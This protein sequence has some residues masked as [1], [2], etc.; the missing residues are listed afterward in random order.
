LNILLSC[1]SNK[2]LVLEWI[3]ITIKNLNIKSKVFAG[4][5]D[6]NVVSKYFCD[7]FWHMPILKEKNFQKIFRFLKKKRIRFI[8]PSS[9]KELHFWAKYKYF[10]KKNKIFV[11]VSELKTINLCIDKLKFYNFLKDNKN[12][13]FTSN[14][15]ENFK[16]KTRLVAKNRYGYGSKNIFLNLSKKEIDLIKEKKDFVY[17]EFIKGKEFS[18]DCF[19]DNNYNLI[20]CSSRYRNKINNGESEITT[21]FRSSKIKKVI[22]NISKKFKFQGH[23]MFQGILSKKY[24]IKIFE[25]NPRLGG[26]SYLSS[27]QFLDSIRYFIWENIFL[28]KKN[29]NYNSNKKIPNK[30][31][32]VIYKSVKLLTN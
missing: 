23:V 22:A 32:M 5:S 1:S 10:L 21:V 17:Q 26:A 6:D 12:I 8:F 28:K 15:L 30:K 19:F 7:Y 27:F 18:V 25:C 9:D 24:N 4:D 29:F 16:N 2:T 3:Y 13:I 20:S 11:M 14:N 31:K